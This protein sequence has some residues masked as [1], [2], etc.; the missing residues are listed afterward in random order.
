MRI[1]YLLTFAT[2]MIFIP[3]LFMTVYK[4]QN[5]K[6]NIS[7]NVASN[8]IINNQK[9]LIYNRDMIETLLKDVERITSDTTLIDNIDFNDEDNVKLKL[10]DAVETLLNHNAQLHK[11]IQMQSKAVVK[12]KNQ[13]KFVEK[14]LNFEFNQEFTKISDNFIDPS[15]LELS[16]SYMNWKKNTT[17]MPKYH[18]GKGNPQAKFIFG[19]PT[20]FRNKASYLSRTLKNL[21][22]NLTPGEKV[23][24]QFI[25]F[26]G[27]TNHTI[28]ESIIED[29]RK[30]FSQEIDDGLLEIISPPDEWYPDMTKL[31]KTLNDPDV[32][33]R[34]R[35]KQNLDFAY[36][37][38]YARS[39]SGQYFVQLEDDIVSKPSYVLE[40]TNFIKIKTRTNPDWLIL[41]FCSLG[42][43]GKLFRTSDLLSFVVQYLIFYNDKPVDWLLADYSRTKICSL[44]SSPKKCN[45]NVRSIWISKKPSLFQHVGTYS[46][47]EGKIQ[48]LQ[49]KQFDKDKFLM[50]KHQ[51]P[52]AIVNTTLKINEGYTFDKIYKGDDFFWSLTP[53][54]KDYLRIIFNEPQYLKR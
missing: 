40:M 16:P 48:K 27:E 7:E 8:D 34:W 50:R 36:L 43:I 42:F 32:R 19:V 49:D 2:I 39:K 22:D 47:L 38:L 17:F 18:I 29:I 12:L 24:S 46:S 6:H 35:T 5:H 14:L 13:G 45:I 41:D 31:R 20:V 53:T 10:V 11:Q 15:L 21:F 33:V 9:E 4:P 26:I 25:V 54:D 37:W 28:I 23:I 44:D 51:N 3:F 1:R 30:Y 52:D